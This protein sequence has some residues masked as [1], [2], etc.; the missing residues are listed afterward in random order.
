MFYSIRSK[1]IV[2]LLCVSLFVGAVSVFSGVR[3]LKKHV[4][5]EAT[6]RVRMDLNAASEMYRSRVK[7]IRISL[8][9]TSLGS[10][11]ISSVA[12]RKTKDL[13]YRLNRL[14]RQ[15]ELDF[16][17]IA[18]H[19]GRLLCRICPNPTVRNSEVPKNPI[20]RLALERQAAVEGTVL[21]TEAMLKQEDPELAARA[22]IPL[23]NGETGKEALAGGL[24]M[25]AAVP[26][27]EGN[28][29][30]AVL[31]GGKLLN[32]SETLVDTVRDTV[33]QGETYQGRNIGTATVF[34]NETRIA[35]NVLTPGG[36]RA[37]GT[38]VSPEIKTAVLDNGQHWTGR[39]YVVSD[40]YIT[41][42]E[43]I[44]DITGQ[45]IGILYVGVLEKKY[46][47]IQKQA[48]TFFILITAAG[49]VLAV[50]LGFMLANRIMDPV[51]RLIQAS[52][53][54]S[55]GSLQPDIGP[56]LKGEFGVMQNT[57][58]EMVAAVGHRR[59]ASESKIIQS[60]KQ[61]SVGRLAAG[62]AHEINN[63]LTGVLTYT[64]LLLRRDDLNPEVRED[65]ETIEAATQRVRKIVK[66]LLDFSRQTVLD[67]EPADINTL[68]RN[69][70]SLL[71]N[72]ALVKGVAVKFTPGEH[73]P[74]VTL[75]RSRMQSVLMNLIINALDATPQWGT[76][77][78]FTA[79]GL[80]GN[81]L[82]QS[83]IEITV[84]DTGSGIHPDHM[85]KLFDP[86]FTTKAVGQGTGLG[87]SV[88]QGIIRRHGGYIR[89]QSE[90]GKGT[91]FFIWLPIKRVK[92]NENNSGR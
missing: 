80:A 27:F 89:V 84:A 24:V 1:L 59:A 90:P 32:R 55:K 3:L 43:P 67:P 31:Y 38:R 53:Q 2:S 39:D 15:G 47:D 72:Q 73:L 19:D 40:W 7:Y 12:A 29:V 13:V 21:L 92:Q 48:L 5:G 61:A 42:Y 78:I 74:K 37:I 14:A 23:L 41:A 88:S 28:T 51:N 25:A 6:N 10:G 70:V 82:N 22:R 16:A 83:G 76:I 54:V 34:L 9:I 33:F 20:Y 81:G 68:V 66:G 17:G 91:R 69:T 65:L 50:G 87:L 52:R 4:I 18:T 45:R 35:T 57:F 60:E 46:T 86:F 62:V 49:M 11:F 58:K 79:V 85:G 63:P 64:H 36:K 71:E 8:S 26:I 77:R 44:E 30:I 56:I 75:D